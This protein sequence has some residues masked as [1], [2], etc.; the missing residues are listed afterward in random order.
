MLG[1]P[2]EEDKSGTCTQEDPRNLAT[3][4]NTI[5]KHQQ[6][7]DCSNVLLGQQVIVMVPHVAIVVPHVPFLQP[8]WSYW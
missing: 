6:A 5:N 4:I 8:E 7:R 2:K 3:G 1:V